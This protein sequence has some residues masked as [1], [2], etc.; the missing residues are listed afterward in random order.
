MAD[1]RLF[2]K[3]IMFT[4][5]YGAQLGNISSSHRPLGASLAPEGPVKAINSN[6]SHKAQAGYERF[7]KFPKPAPTPAPLYQGLIPVVPRHRKPEGDATCFNSALEMIIIPD[8]IEGLP[9][10]FRAVYDKNPKKYYAVKAFP[11]TGQVQVTGVVCPDL[12]DGAWV[13]RLLASYMTQAGAG[14][15]AGQPIAVV[16][17]RP[18][19]VNFK[20]SLI[21][22][23]DRVVLNLARIVAHLDAMKLRDEGLPF[24]I[25]ELRRPQDSQNLSFKFV[26]PIP[27]PLV[28]RATKKVRVNIYFR[29]KV[30]ILG[31]CDFEVPGT[32]YAFL[33]ALFR[34]HWDEFVGLKPLPDSMHR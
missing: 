18:I 4:C 24:P 1:P 19:M 21:H 27:H 33:T 10:P 6:F 13:V 14:N 26:C 23:S 25:R 30:N 22:P 31:A 3:P 11:S 28:G 8:E 12:S 20:F 2:T 32:I 17:E 9:A 16:R 5:T 15:D 29:G 7:L 34:E